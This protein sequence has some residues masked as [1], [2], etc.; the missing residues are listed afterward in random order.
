MRI[1]KKLLVLPLSLLIFH[2]PAQAAKDDDLDELQTKLSNQWTLVKNDQ[3]HG[4]KTYA[5]QE[6]GKRFRSFKV[7][8]VMDGSMET[9][10]RMI[11]DF[12][13]Y[14]KWSWQ[15]L[16]SKLLKKVSPTEYYFYV[17][18]D[19][20]YG[21]PDRDVAL[22]M[23]LEPQAPNKPYMTVKINAVPDYIPERPP[24]V[25]MQAEDMTCRVTP[26]PNGK[27][28]VINEG[29]VDPG[30]NMASWAINFVQRNGPYTTLLGMRR[31]LQQEELVNAKTPLPFAVFNVDN[32]P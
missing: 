14:K 25:R 10:L 21:V 24:Y 30:G 12:D 19:A 28:L 18:H 2:A 11:T 15:A 9:F 22:R 3:R 29:Y 32:L 23:V 7:E 4:L 20:P 6:D 31:M 8:A 26:L 27:L 1:P 5:K 16:D 17:T 13:N